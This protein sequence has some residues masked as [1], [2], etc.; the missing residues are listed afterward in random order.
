MQI[1]SDLHIE[2]NTD[3]IPDPLRYFTPTS[4]TLI[5]AGDVGSLYKIDQLYGFLF[6]VCNLYKN[7]IYV[8][9]NHEYYH[10]KGYKYLSMKVLSERLESIGTRIRNLTILN[11]KSIQLTGDDNKPVIVL[12]STLWSD[13]LTDLPKYIVR[14]N[15]MTTSRYIEMHKRSVGYIHRITQWCKLK[16]V[17]LIIVTHYPPTYKILNG[18]IRP[19]GTLQ[20]KLGSLY[21]S[22]LEKLITPTVDTWV[23]GHVHVNFDYVTS[24]GTRMTSNQVGKPRDKITDYS[25]TKT[26]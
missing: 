21:A 23:S 4:N 2:Y 25:K 15:G 11:N 10:V 12:G 19:N 17:R 3:L 14:I 9:G 1:A 13:L 24:G 18:K 5:L 8:P 26:V 16:G 22:H 7:V 20:K 6:K